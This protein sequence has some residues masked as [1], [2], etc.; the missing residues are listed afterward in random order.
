MR[1][2]SAHS[3]MLEEAIRARRQVVMETIAAGVDQEKY[4]QFVGQIRG[5]DDAL[6]LSN[7]AD[8]K[9]NGDHI[10]DR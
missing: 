2:Q 3:R 9:L 6:A 8:S 10:A 5:L 4:H 1:F 7:E